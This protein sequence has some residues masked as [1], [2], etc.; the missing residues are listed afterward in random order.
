MGR[1]TRPAIALRQSLRAPLLLAGLMLARG[2]RGAHT[3]VGGDTCCP[4]TCCDP[5]GAP[6]SSTPSLCTRA[7]AAPARR[8]ARPP[9]THAYPTPV[10]ANTHAVGPGACENNVYC[11]WWNDTSCWTQDDHGDGSAAAP[12]PHDHTIVHHTGGHACE[13]HMPAEGVDVDA[14]TFAGSANV[15]L[16]ASEPATMTV[17]LVRVSMNAGNA[18][19]VNTDWLQ[20]AVRRQV[21]VEQGELLWQ[22]SDI[23]CLGHALA[24]PAVPQCN[25]TVSSSG[26]ASLLASDAHSTQ[27]VRKLCVNFLVEAG[28]ALNIGGREFGRYNVWGGVLET[29]GTVR[30]AGL[31]WWAEDRSHDVPSGARWRV[32]PPGS[33]AFGRWQLNTEVWDSLVSELWIGKPSTQALELR[34]PL[35]QAGT[36]EVGDGVSVQLQGGG[37]GSGHFGLLGVDSRLEVHRTFEFKDSATFRGACSGSPVECSA[38]WLRARTPDEVA[39]SSIGLAGTCCGYQYRACGVAFKV[40][41]NLR[42][43]GTFSMGSSCSMRVEDVDGH[44]AALQGRGSVSP[45]DVTINDGTSWQTALSA[46]VEAHPGIL[47]DVSFLNFGSLHLEGYHVNNTLPARESVV[48][49]KL[50]VTNLTSLRAVSR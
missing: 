39:A 28:G 5:S 19:F 42:F 35:E 11:K 2:A 4:A 10:C 34:F 26:T 38:I 43:T 24:C 1:L 44:L 27:Q 8:G 45:A 29:S 25:M 22:G 18:V 15:V 3:W 47:Q 40:S 16:R 17:G 12:G 41:A 48:T 6:A 32:L 21:R 14:I 31:A 7:R 37:L 50:G 30:V 9:L 49:N 23:F 33:L 36:L 13:I 20:L 46:P